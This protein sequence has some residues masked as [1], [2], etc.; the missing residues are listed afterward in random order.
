MAELYL[1]VESEED[2][3]SELGW[4]LACCVLH[5]VFNSVNDGRFQRGPTPDAAQEPLLAHPSAE[6]T[7]STV[8]RHVDAFMKGTGVY[9]Y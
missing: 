3:L 7:C 2:F 5:N 6:A 8:K 4:I 1:P 9:K